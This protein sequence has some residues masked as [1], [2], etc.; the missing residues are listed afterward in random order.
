MTH[1]KVHSHDTQHKV[2]SLHPNNKRSLGPMGPRI[3]S[4]QLLFQKIDIHQELRIRQRS[5]GTSGTYPEMAP[6]W[7][8]NK[9]WPYRDK[10]F[11]YYISKQ[12]QRLISIMNSD[13][14]LTLHCIATGCCSRG[15]TSWERLKELQTFSMFL[16]VFLRE[17]V[18]FYF[19][20]TLTQSTPDYW[21]VFLRRSFGTM[22]SERGGVVCSWQYCWLLKEWS[23][24][25]CSGGAPFS[26]LLQSVTAGDQ[27]RS[28]SS[29]AG[30][31]AHC[32]GM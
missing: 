9:L 6:G 25:T 29:S 15:I 18:L 11:R 17:K 28:A 1:R 12:P 22:L 14:K 27:Q 21:N 30:W 31:K 26:A 23:T 7:L 3:T 19:S 10:G 2:L 32:S 16:L 5:K 24:L 8:N 4:Q 20:N 13:A